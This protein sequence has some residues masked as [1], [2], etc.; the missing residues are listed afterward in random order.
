MNQGALLARIYFETYRIPFDKNNSENC[1]LMQK[2]V[3]MLTLFGF[4]VNYSDEEYGFTLNQGQPFSPGIKFTLQEED[5]VLLDSVELCDGAKETI[6]EIKRII[7]FAHEGYSLLLWV[8]AITTLHFLNNHFY[9]Y[10]DDDDELSLLRRLKNY[11]PDLNNSD[12]NLL[13][14]EQSKLLGC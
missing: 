9:P 10:D 2:A 4:S 13:A 6:Q 1:E 8:R 14:F 3:Y 5:C 12:L 11:D 7:N